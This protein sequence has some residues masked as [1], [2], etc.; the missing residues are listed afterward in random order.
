MP[1]KVIPESTTPDTDT[2]F[3]PL[4]IVELTEE[5][6]SALDAI[7]KPKKTSSYTLD[8]INASL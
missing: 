6:D 2:P 5:Q 4:F 3:D 7:T 1:P 8:E